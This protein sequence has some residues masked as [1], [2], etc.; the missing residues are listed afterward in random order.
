MISRLHGD[1]NTVPW[2]VPLKTPG[3][4][5]ETAV[6][7][8]DRAKSPSAIVLLILL[9]ND[10]NVVLLLECSTQKFISDAY[11]SPAAALQTKKT[12]MNRDTTEFPAALLMRLRMKAVLF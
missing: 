1:E 3:P 7:E 6:L 4:T 2:L 8:I 12:I 9:N 5:S 11:T 10:F